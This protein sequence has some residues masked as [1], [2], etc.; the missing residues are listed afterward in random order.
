MSVGCGDHLLGEEAV[1][2]L[3]LRLHAWRFRQYH[4]PLVVM[5]L[6]IRIAAVFFPQRWQVTS[7]SAYVTVLL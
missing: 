5:D 1:F 3:A 4:S 7:L 6:C 2:H